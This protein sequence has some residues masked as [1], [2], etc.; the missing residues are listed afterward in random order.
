MFKPM[1]LA[2]V[3]IA[4]ATLLFV[5]A[6]PSYAQHRG[7]GGGGGFHGGGGGWGGGYHGGEFRGGGYRGGFWGGGLWLGAPYYGGYY[8]SYGYPY[9][10]YPSNYYSYP[11]PYD[12]YQA[13]TAVIPGQGYYATSN[14]EVN[15]ALID[16]RVPANAQVFVDGKLTQQQGTERLFHTPPLTPGQTYAYELQA[17]WSANGAPTTVPRQVQVEAGKEAFVNFMDATP[18]NNK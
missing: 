13:P 1:F 3:A 9:Y 5:T 12:S 4:A 8:G 16:V 18:D 2:K 10:A 7:G 11:A 14:Q 17:T 6:G 15:S